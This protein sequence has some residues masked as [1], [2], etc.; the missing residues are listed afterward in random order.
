MESVCIIYTYV[1]QVVFFR[2]VSHQNLYVPF[3]SPYMP[4]APPTPPTLFLFDHPRRIL[5]V[6]D[7]SFGFALGGMV[8]I[9]TL[10]VTTRDETKLG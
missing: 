10:P 6:E 5:C 8:I 7:Y 3:F 4:H 1:N 9:V 2:H